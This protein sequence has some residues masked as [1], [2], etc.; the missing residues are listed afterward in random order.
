MSLNKVLPLNNLW[1]IIELCISWGAA[2]T[3]TNDNPNIS[4]IISHSI[5]EMNRRRLRNVIAGRWFPSIASPS[6]GVVLDY[7]IL[8]GFI[9]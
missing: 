7:T 3:D 1:F 4:R 9:I 8:A 6:N 2:S 5:I